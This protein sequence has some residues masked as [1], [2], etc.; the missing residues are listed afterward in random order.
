MIKIKIKRFRAIDIHLMPITRVSTTSSQAILNRKKKNNHKRGGISSKTRERG[1]E[2]PQTQRTRLCTQ[3]ILS[4]SEAP[5]RPFE[6][7]RK[8]SAKSESLT[9]RSSVASSTISLSTSRDQRRLATITLVSLLGSGFLLFLNVLPQSIT[10]SQL[11]LHPVRRLAGHATHTTGRILNTTPC[12]LDTRLGIL[13]Q[14]R[15]PRL[16]TL[17]HAL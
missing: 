15:E 7:A 11:I 4:S 16:R 1:K 12:R 9:N 13:W 8:Y 14:R 17:H 6:P 10:P 5:K 3:R 2:T